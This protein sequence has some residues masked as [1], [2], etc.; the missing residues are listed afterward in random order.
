MSKQNDYE[1]VEAWRKQQATEAAAA[2]EKFELAAKAN[3]A[4]AAEFEQTNPD[5][6]AYYREC[7]SAARQRAEYFK[8]RHSQY[9]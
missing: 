7:A 9:A 1:M 2:V 3:D 8:E 6:A 5:T 4:L